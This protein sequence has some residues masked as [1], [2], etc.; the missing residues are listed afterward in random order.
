MEAIKDDEFQVIRYVLLDLIFVC[1]FQFKQYV[2]FF[3]ICMC[4][5]MKIKPK[6]YYREGC[7]P[8]LRSW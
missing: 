4:F 8:Y 6:S 2:Y 7:F 5:S 1:Q 3:P